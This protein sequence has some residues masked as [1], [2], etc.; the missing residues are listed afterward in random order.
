MGGEKTVMNMWST[1]NFAGTETSLFNTAV[2]DTDHYI[3]VQT[4]RISCTT[5][6]VE[7]DINKELQL[8]VV[9]QHC[10]INCYK[11]T[12]PTKTLVTEETVGERSIK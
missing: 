7:L 8:I 11:Y 12:I 1:G 6:T 9:Y 3:F 2:V 10:L 5:L 4:H